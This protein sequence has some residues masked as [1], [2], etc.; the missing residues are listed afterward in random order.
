MDIQPVEKFLIGK[1]LDF[2]FIKSMINK[3]ETYFSNVL[4]AKASKFNSIGSDGLIIVWRKT[5]KELIYS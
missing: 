1:N 2:S 4:F 3:P 5:N